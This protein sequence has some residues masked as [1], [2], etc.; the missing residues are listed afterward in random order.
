MKYIVRDLTAKEDWCAMRYE[1]IIFDSIEDADA[2]IKDWMQIDI[3]NG[4][5]PHSYITE[6]ILPERAQ[7]LIY[8]D[9][10]RREWRKK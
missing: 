10:V 7:E 5:E 8:H 3:E 6:K 9:K 1:D 2:A 4:D